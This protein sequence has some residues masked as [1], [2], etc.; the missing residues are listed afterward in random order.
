MIQSD[1]LDDVE[2][3]LDDD[4]RVALVDQPVDHQQQLADVLE[5]QPGGGLVEDVDGAAVGALLQ[6]GS[7]L[8]ALRLA[9]GERG[10][11]LAE[12]DV[13]EPDVDERAQVAGDRGD[14][15]EELRRLLDGH[16]EDLGH[17]LA[18]VV[19]LEGLPVVPGALA[20]LAR[21]VD[22]RQEVHLDLDRAVAGARLAAPALDV[23]R[24]AAGLVAADLRLGGGREQLA[25][26]VPD[27][28][29]GGRV[30]PRGAPDRRLVDPDQ[31]VELV[32]TGD[33]GVPAGHLPRAVELVGQH[34]G[35]DVVDQR[36]LARAG[37]PGDRDQAAERDVDVDA[38][39]VVLARAD[40]RQ[41]P[42]A[43][44]RPAD[45]RHRDRAAP[46]QVRA[47]QRRVVRLQPGHGAAVHDVA[48]VLAGAGA[49]VDRPVGRADRV[50]VVLDD[51]QGVAQVAQPDQGLDEPA[52]V[53]LVQPDR[54]LVEHVEHA[55][56]ARP[57]LRGEPDALGLAA[58][59][60]SRRPAS[61]DR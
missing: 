34:R 4:H 37:H 41:L 60:R 38:A 11:R 15:R 8:D 13:A 5:V 44:D 48:A 32:E 18:L 26:L 46:G 29:V 22:V 55:D 52:V 53:A 59:E 1:G 35:Q 28:G 54:R 27:A 21:H 10:R 43:V 3:V 23:E 33:A 45:V 19:D 58:G 17:R 9:A 7:E 25:D 39:Q 36:G 47:G 56:Q 31:L 42:L 30:G 50:L 61:S 51:D 24:E 14:R 6:L 12:P 49:D 2:V 40:D 16:V 20:H 57:D